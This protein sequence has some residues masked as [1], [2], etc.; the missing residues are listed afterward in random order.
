MN[1]NDK[2]VQE[3]RSSLNNFQ[4]LD[5]SKIENKFEFECKIT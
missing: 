1:T 5:C 2:Y 4:N 3:F